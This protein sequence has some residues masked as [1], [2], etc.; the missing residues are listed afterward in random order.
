MN[1]LSCFR[2]VKSK[3]QISPTI[4]FKEQQ[5]STILF[6]IIY[7]NLYVLIFLSLKVISIFIFCLLYYAA[8]Q[9]KPQIFVIFWKSFKQFN[10]IHSRN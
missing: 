1:I 10:Q 3:L 9:G 8:V 5:T 6:T 4:D 2:Y 7:S